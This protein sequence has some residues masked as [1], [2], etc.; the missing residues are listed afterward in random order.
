MALVTLS[1]GKRF[2]AEP[3][4]L[5]LDAAARAGLVLEHSCRTGRCGACK[6]RVQA[7][8]SCAT[9]ALRDESGLTSVER[10]AGWILTCARAA[11]ADVTI[12]VEDL[13]VEPIAVAKTYP[14]RIQGLERL[15]KDVVKVQLRLPPVNDFSFRP[16]QHV[17]LIGRDGLRRSYS[18]ANAPRPDGTIE[19][20]VRRVVDGAMSAYWFDEAKLGDLLRLHGPRG[21][22]F[23]RGIDGRDLVFLATGT[24]IAPVKAMLQS[25]AGRACV[26]PRS[27]SIYW[28]GRT[29]TD[30]Y[31]D[32]WPELSNEQ[33]FF[34]VL[35]RAHAGWKGARGYV[36]Q[37]ALGQA[38]DWRN[39]TVYACGSA[40]MIVDA[41]RQ[42]VNAGLDDRRFHA[43][44]FLRSGPG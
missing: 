18:M 34:P 15:H 1:N 10:A 44:A 19:L 32:G 40:P 24:G 22:F 6:G 8:S 7:E 5:L 42:L 28:G 31:R 37:A 13:S 14:C 23:L 41:R 25:L 3:G 4:E 36:Q 21:A 9:V 33:R 29:H 2:A 12:E 16:G 17:D 11:N 30:L 39:T 43:D 27:A 35:S 26:R 38:H 20:H